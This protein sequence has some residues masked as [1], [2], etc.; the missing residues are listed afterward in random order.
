[1][2]FFNLSN[3]Y[4]AALKLIDE[5]T[6]EITVHPQIQHEVDS[7]VEQIDRLKAFDTPLYTEQRIKFFFPEA[8]QVAESA[9]TDII[10]K[11][12]DISE[13]IN[14]IDA[15]IK[16]MTE[17]QLL[18]FIREFPYS[19]SIKISFKDVSTVLEAL[20]DLDETARLRG[21]SDVS[22]TPFEDNV[23]LAY[24]LLRS[25]EINQDNSFIKKLV[26]SYE[27]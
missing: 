8:V 2:K 22:D 25:A 16:G 17:A 7:M 19:N 12:E 4:P 21:D 23:K 27:G 1:M 14:I 24:T 5:K 18:D 10:S 6:A 11:V 9:Y 20:S 26:K 3:V 13:K 15:E